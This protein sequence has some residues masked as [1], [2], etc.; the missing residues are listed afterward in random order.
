MKLAVFFHVYLPDLD[1]CLPILAEQV[2]ALEA[3]GLVD[4]AWLQVGAC[5]EAAA[6]PLLNCWFGGRVKFSP[7]NTGE[8]HT[9]RLLQQ[10]LPGHR[11]WQVCYHH[12]KGISHKNDAY[13]SWRR[14]MQKNVIEEWK[15]CVELLERGADT[16]GCHWL[17]SDRYPVIP[18][19]QRYWGGNFW[20]ATARHLLS[21]PP[22]PEP[23]RPDGRYYDGEVWIGQTDR[24]IQ[25]RD[26]APH[27]PQKGCG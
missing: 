3:S 22:L 24:P 26:L 25:V 5:G 17:S 2:D 18:A 12:T 14:C 16:V 9:L 6:E 1:P 4:A 20:W 27:W 15:L 23:N 8:Y 11:D 13:G 21:L 19:R 10:W 7:E